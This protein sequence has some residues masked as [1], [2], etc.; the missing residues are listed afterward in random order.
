MT[1]PRHSR[2]HDI[3]ERAGRERDI[4]RRGGAAFRLD[5]LRPQHAVVDVLERHRHHLGLAVDGDMAEEL[6]P[7]ARREVVL[8]ALAAA[9]LEYGARAEGVVE[10][11]RR[12][13]AGMD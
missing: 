5:L 13:G 3:L 7:E 11:P 10:P 2:P 6:Q 1:A 8:L 9:H 12:P 4:R